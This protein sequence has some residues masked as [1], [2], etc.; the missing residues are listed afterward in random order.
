MATFQLSFQ[1]GRAKDLSA[2]LYLS[3]HDS[4]SCNGTLHQGTAIQIQSTV[5][6]M[7]LMTR[8]PSV[9][10]TSLCGNRVFYA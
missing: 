3:Q 4:M 2:L 8:K 6:A 7:H 10:Y 5:I 1:S 9:N